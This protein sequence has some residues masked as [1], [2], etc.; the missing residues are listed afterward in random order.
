MQDEAT[1]RREA[2]LKASFRDLTAP[3]VPFGRD[4]ES[5]RTNKAFAG[6]SDEVLQHRAH[7]NLREH[8]QT[9]NAPVTL[10]L[11]KM[12]EDELEAIK[13]A[14]EIELASRNGVD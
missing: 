4:G 12:T 7:F 3:E 2:E 8:M 6:I 11:I 10:D 13:Q 14:A 9:V 1:A 5:L